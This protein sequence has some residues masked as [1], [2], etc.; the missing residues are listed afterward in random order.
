[1]AIVF[2]QSR[3]KQKYLIFVLIFMVFLFLFLRFFLLKSKPEKVEEIIIMKTPLIE[4]DF[5][6]LESPTLE[7]LEIFEEIPALEEFGRENP[8]LPY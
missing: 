1:M 5:S 3:K 7:R 6:V 2:R 4:I 8:F